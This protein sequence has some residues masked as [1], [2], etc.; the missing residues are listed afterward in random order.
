MTMYLTK[1]WGFSD[2]SGPLQFSARGWLDRARAVLKDGDLVAIV[3]TQGA[4]TLDPERGMLL[5]LMEPSTHTVRCLDYALDVEPHDYDD[6]G[7]YRWPFGLELKAA[8]RFIEPL[9]PLSSVSSR[10]FTMDSALGIVPLEPAE[11]AKILALLRAPASLLRPLAAAARI[12]GTDAARRR[13]AP[14]PTTT[15]QGVMHMRRMS[16]FTYAMEI[17]HATQAAFKIGWSFDHKA[18]A[19][20]FNLYSLPQLGGLR[21]RIRFQQL[22]ETAMDA[23]RMEQTL[24]R[25]F[26]ARRHPANREV[27]TP[28]SLAEL[29]TAWIGYLATKPKLKA[30]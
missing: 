10:S 9:M 25:K 22:W 8:W 2:P 20:Q 15:R 5:G 4:P 29:E 14:P 17:E 30:G 24:L 26:D 12:E 13:A 3:G 23:F 16:A 19:G 27:V 21:Y 28:L 6:D 18:R 1:T 11:A 7:N